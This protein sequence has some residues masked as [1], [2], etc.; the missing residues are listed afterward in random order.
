MGFPRREYWSGLP[1]PSS[2]DLPHQRYNPSHQQKVEGSWRRGY[3]AQ[4]SCS[5]PGV[6]GG[7]SGKE[8]TCQC[9]RHRRCGFNPWAGKINWRREWQPTPVFSPGKFHGQRSMAGY[10]PWGRKESD[11]TERLHFHF[12]TCVLRTKFLQKIP[13]T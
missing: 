13:S 8:S 2:R 1:F 9:T 12:L 3:V 10:S 4:L 6:P 5:E 7:A 11:M